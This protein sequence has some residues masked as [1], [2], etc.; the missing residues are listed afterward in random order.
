[1]TPTQ[2]AALV[3]SQ[4]EAARRLG[5]S[6]TALQ[7]AVQAGRIHPEPGGGWDVEKLRAQLAASADPA[8]LTGP[9][10]PAAGTES[11]EPAAG[12][13]LGARGWRAPA[14]VGRPS[15]TPAPQT[16]C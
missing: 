3:G 6:H 1:M 12:D 7:K 10:L 14:R 16:R 15:T 9:S 11:G 2:D 8:R 4:R 5:L 13:P